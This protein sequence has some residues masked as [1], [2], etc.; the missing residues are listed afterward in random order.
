[1]LQI[2]GNGTVSLPP[3][4]TPTIVVDMASELPN[5]S[6]DVQS[7]HNSAAEMDASAEQ[8]AEPQVSLTF[9]L[10]SGRR[11]TYAFA[12]DCSIAIVKERLLREWPSGQASFHS[13]TTLLLIKYVFYLISLE[14]EDEMKPQ[15][16]SQIR[17]LHYGRLLSDDET[18]S[19]STFELITNDIMD[20]RH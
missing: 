7:I 1:M 15:A 12:Q 5:S 20:T 18:L 3:S 2:P 6:E 8:G 14:W 10:L 13:A 11:K 9:L 19:A 17:L 16:V 4:Q